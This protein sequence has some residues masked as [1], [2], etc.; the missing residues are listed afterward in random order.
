MIV[1]VVSWD[2]VFVFDLPLLLFVGM[3]AA[4]MGFACEMGAGLPE[5]QCSI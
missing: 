2:N 5:Y 4:C 1:F 3:D